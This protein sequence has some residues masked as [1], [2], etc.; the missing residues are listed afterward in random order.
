MGAYNVGKL[1]ASILG[2]RGRR[3][4]RGK[5]MIYGFNKIKR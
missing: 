3:G 5:E 2:R 1:I 4:E